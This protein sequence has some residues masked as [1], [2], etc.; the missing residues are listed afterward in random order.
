MTQY[1]KFFAALLTA[2]LLMACGKGE[3]EPE[4]RFTVVRFNFINACTF[5]AGSKNATYCDCAFN[6]ILKEFGRDAVI[7]LLDVGDES[8]LSNAEDIATHKSMREFM[9]ATPEGVCKEFVKK[10][11]PKKAEEK[12]FFRKLIPEK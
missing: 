10:D 8:E 5:Y 7:R 4:H 2:L 11:D 1:S 12:P 9:A 3:E 6:E